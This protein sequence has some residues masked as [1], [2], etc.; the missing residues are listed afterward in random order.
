[1][2]DPEGD[3]SLAEGNRMA[4]GGI[5]EAKNSAGLRGRNADWVGEGS[6]WESTAA[7]E[8]VEDRADE[9]LVAETAAGAG[10]AFVAV[11]SAVRA[12]R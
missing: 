1:M 9:V 12:A 4:L 8:I 6:M 10:A 3:T 2:L 11:D 7:V 5:H